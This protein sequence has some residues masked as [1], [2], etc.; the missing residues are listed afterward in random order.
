MLYLNIFTELLRIKMNP[1]LIKPVLL[2][3]F[4]RRISKWKDCECSLIFRNP[5]DLFHFL[6]PL[7]DRSNSKPDS[8]KSD[9]ISH[10]FSIAILISMSA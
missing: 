3:S 1:A 8:A 7:F 5:N 4:L 10:K 9:F 2:R 6:H